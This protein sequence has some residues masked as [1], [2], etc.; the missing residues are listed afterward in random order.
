[1]AQGIISAVGAKPRR[2]PTAAERAA[3]IEAMRADLAAAEARLRAV[4]SFATADRLRCIAGDAE[5]YGRR[6]ITARAKAWAVERLGGQPSEGD[7]LIETAI[8]VGMLRRAL[9]RAGG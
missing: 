5:R 1:M 8:Q 6:A 7:A 2:R 9:A 3:R 4:P